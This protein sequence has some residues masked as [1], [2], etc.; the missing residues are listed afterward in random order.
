M[1]L[2][3][4]LKT[5]YTRAGLLGRY[6]LISAIV[7][8]TVDDLIPYIEEEKRKYARYIMEKLPEIEEYVKQLIEKYRPVFEKYSRNRDTVDYKS[9]RD[10][11]SQSSFN[12]GFL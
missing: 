10:Y 12:R 11:I 9:F 8:G 5:P 2:Q 3:V 7:T 1:L 4:K 6:G